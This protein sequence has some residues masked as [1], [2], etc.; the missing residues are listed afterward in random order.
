ML[1]RAS[2]LCCAVHSQFR[3][4][5]TASP[6]SMAVLGSQIHTHSALYTAFRDWS[7][8]VKLKWLTLLP[9][10]PSPGLQI[11]LV[12]SKRSLS[13]MTFMAYLTDRLSDLPWC[14]T[15]RIWQSQKPA[16]Y[17]LVTAD[18]LIPHLD[19]CLLMWLELYVS[20]GCPGNERTGILFLAPLVTLSR[21]FHDR[22]SPPSL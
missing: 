12:I 22:V 14:N 3:T 9:T 6:P 5:P 21:W 7:R 10:E 8:S 18:I 4:V 17:C 15:N 19:S 2:N 16:S 1:D 13:Y 20:Q 11:S